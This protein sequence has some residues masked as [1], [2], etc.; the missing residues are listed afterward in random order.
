[1]DKSKATEPVRRLTVQEVADLRA[2]MKQAA[3]WARKELARRHSEKK[4]TNSP[5]NPSTQQL[6]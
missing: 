3:E 5:N 1:M 4:V 2:D 6:Q